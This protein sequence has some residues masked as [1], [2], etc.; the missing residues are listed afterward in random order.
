MQLKKF[1]NNF[2]N[3]FKKKKFNEVKFDNIIESKIIIERSGEIFKKSLL[4]FNDD[5]G[6]TF[7]LRPDLTIAACLDYLKNKRKG[8]FKYVYF[9]QAYRRTFS[10]KS[11]VRNQLGCEVIGNPSFKADLEVLNNIY[12]TLKKY[13]K[14]N[15]KIKVNDISLFNNFIGS[16]NLPKRWKLRFIR[17][18]WR[19]SYFNELLKR[20]KS[21]SDIDNLVFKS[22]K[23]IFLKLKKNNQKSLIA[24]RKISDITSRF[25]KKIKQPRSKIDG[26]K[27]YRIINEFLNIETPLDKLDLRLNQFMKKYKLKFKTNVNFNKKNFKNSKIFFSAAVGRGAEYYSG[28]V[29]EIFSAN[30]SQPIASGGRYNNLIQTLGSKRKITATGGA[31]NY[32]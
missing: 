30:N 14:K 7:S 29:F 24:G 10:S 31:V 27:I 19:Q 25:E 13:Q 23:N 8:V 5:N 16:L 6:K 12:Y 18:F 22:D 20:L 9:D 21:G 15:I 2:L 11:L 3:Y 28:F 4:S 26:K 1:S 17:H 32:D